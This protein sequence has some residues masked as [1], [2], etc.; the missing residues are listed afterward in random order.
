[1]LKRFLEPRFTHHV[2][3]EDFS[4]NVIAVPDRAVDRQSQ[5]VPAQDSA[6]VEASFLISEHCNG[7]ASPALQSYPPYVP[8]IEPVD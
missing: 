1:M 2:D 8:E 4:V 5:A 6:V 7:L 3:H